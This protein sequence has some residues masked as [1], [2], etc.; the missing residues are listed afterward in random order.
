MKNF[1]SKLKSVLKDI[2]IVFFYF[3]VGVTCFVLPIYFG[4]ELQYLFVVYF[5]KGIIDITN[6]ANGK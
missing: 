6:R 4:W 3:A 2:A 1:W 5:I